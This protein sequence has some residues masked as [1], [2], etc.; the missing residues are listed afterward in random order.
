MFFKDSSRL[1]KEGHTLHEPNPYYH[2]VAR[3]KLKT[4]TNTKETQ[5]QTNA[6][7]LLSVPRRCVLIGKNAPG[8]PR[9]RLRLL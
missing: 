9:Q 3:T 6:I 8:S 1:K 5:N 2:Y 4:H 7:T